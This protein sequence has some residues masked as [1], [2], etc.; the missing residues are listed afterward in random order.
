MSSISYNNPFQLQK[1]YSKPIASKQAKPVSQPTLKSTSRAF[2]ALKM[3]RFMS[4]GAATDSFE[5]SSR[6][7]ETVSMSRQTQV[8]SQPQRMKSKLE[9][10]LQDTQSGLLQAL[11]SPALKRD[12]T[13]LASEEWLSD[14]PVYD[15]MSIYQSP[16]T[17]PWQ[18]VKDKLMDIFFEPLPEQVASTIVAPVNVQ[19]VAKPQQERPIGIAQLT[20]VTF[21][22]AASSVS[23]RSPLD[24]LKKT[25]P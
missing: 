10:Q 17:N 2:G 15:D 3:A 21:S 14:A 11:S 19:P 18:Q 12:A 4:E 13:P 16:L 7:D 23:E 22:S 24:R 8:T 6:F 20:R 25:S 1:Q 9:P 5:S